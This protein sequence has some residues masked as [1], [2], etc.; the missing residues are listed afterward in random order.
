[1]KLSEHGAEILWLAS[2][3]LGPA[4]IAAYLGCDRKSVYN[5]LETHRLDYLWPGRL[6]APAR[7]QG[8]VTSSAQARVA[9]AARP[10]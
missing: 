7:R 10:L 1:M 5:W 4:Q 2:N 9:P 6:G 8:A 3:D